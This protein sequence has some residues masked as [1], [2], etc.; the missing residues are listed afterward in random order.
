[1]ALST[2]GEL[3][4]FGSAHHGELGV[5]MENGNEKKHR[6]GS[7]SKSRV[8]VRVVLDPDAEVDRV[9]ED[10]A[11]LNHDAVSICKTVDG[12]S[13]RWMVK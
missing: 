6:H 7:K 11:T 5:E 3:F 2:S 13:N 1:M 9:V 8:P 4:A 12:V 10:I